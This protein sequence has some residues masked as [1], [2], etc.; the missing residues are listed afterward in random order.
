MGFA[1]LPGHPGHDSHVNFLRRWLVTWQSSLLHPLLSRWLQRA[2][3]CVGLGPPVGCGSLLAPRSFLGVALLGPLPG[4]A[5][6][7][8]LTINRPFHALRPSVHA[9]SPRKPPR[10]CPSR[11]SVFS[12]SWGVYSTCCCLG[13]TCVF[14]CLP[15]LTW[16]LHLPLPLSFPSLC[17]AW[18]LTYV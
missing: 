5:L 13:N 14:P 6:P 3:S 12:L 10:C 2:G 4:N 7:S 8:W 17:L 16:L 1:S 9:S 15:F 11:L 18:F